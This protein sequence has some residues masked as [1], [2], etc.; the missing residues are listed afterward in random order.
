MFGRG[1]D[2]ASIRKMLGQPP[3]TTLTGAGGVGKTRVALQVARGGSTP[4]GCDGMSAKAVA[5][6]N[7]HPK[8]V[9]TLTDQKK[10]TRS[11]LRA[12]QKFAREKRRE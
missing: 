7:K 8:T 2:V 3:L 6:D 5:H 11:P 9:V 10:R 12:K 1:D 4:G